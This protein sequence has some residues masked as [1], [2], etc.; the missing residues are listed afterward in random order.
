MGYNRGSEVMTML[1]TVYVRYKNAFSRT[2]AEDCAMYL[3]ELLRMN[4]YRPNFRFYLIVA[5]NRMFAVGGIDDEKSERWRITDFRFIRDDNFRPY[6]LY[7]APFNFWAG[8]WTTILYGGIV[9]KVQRQRPAS[10]LHFYLLSTDLEL[11]DGEREAGA[12]KEAIWEVFDVRYADG[13]ATIRPLLSDENALMVV[14]LRD[15][16]V[17]EL[18]N[19]LANFVGEVFGQ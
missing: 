17:S 19:H 9:G 1:R 3:S 4:A 10:P 15:L 2:D 13:T 6:F 7:F 5:E 8:E 14:R 16:S 12:T 11:T 18:Y